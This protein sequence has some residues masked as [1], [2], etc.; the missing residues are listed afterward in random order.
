MA[1]APYCRNCSV[2]MT[3]KFMRIHTDDS[4]SIKL[5]HVPPRQTG[6]DVDKHQAKN[7]HIDKDERLGHLKF[8]ASPTAP[9]LMNQRVRHTT[10]V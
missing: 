6:F 8:L 9:Q 2:S 5:G 3:L 1:P 7:K 10:S 4:R